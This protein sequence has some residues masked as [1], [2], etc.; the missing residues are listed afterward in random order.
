MVRLDVNLFTHALDIAGEYSPRRRRN[1]AG[2]V[3]G[4]LRYAKTRQNTGNMKTALLS[5]CLGCDSTMVAM[6]KH[7]E[8]FTY[9]KTLLALQHVSARPFIERAA[10]NAEIANGVEMFDTAIHKL[11][12]FHVDELSPIEHAKA[13]TVPTLVVQVH[14]DVL[15]KPSMCK[16]STTTFPP[17][18]RSCSG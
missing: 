7:P 9:I 16:R 17:R 12:G 4:S 5:V 11:T 1:S 2:D 14:D 15:T 18:T 6:N 3:I 8:E 10:E 13:V